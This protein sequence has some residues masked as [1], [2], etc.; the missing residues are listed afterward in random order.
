[1]KTIESLPFSYGMGKDLK[2]EVKGAKSAIK[3]RIKDAQRRR[4]SEAFRLSILSCD[5]QLDAFALNRVCAVTLYVDFGDESESYGELFAKETKQLLEEEGFEGVFAT[6]P[7]V[8]SFLTTIFGH[9][10]RPEDG[11]SFRDRV[12]RFRTKLAERLKA[13][14]WQKIKKGA[15]KGASV[16]VIA[17]GM[18]GAANA[19]HVDL[20]KLQIPPVVIEYILVGGSAVSVARECKKMMEKKEEP[21][22]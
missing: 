6:E 16:I 22:K 9:S 10:P 5:K 4:V 14:Q 2:R 19:A 15:A 18:A 8:G 1:M 20:T 17:A 11:P 7:E 12:E 21:G 13:F 3:A